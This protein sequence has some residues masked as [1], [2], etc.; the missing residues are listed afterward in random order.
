MVEYNNGYLY[1][2][3]VFCVGYMTT[4]NEVCFYITCNLCW[5]IK[6]LIFFSISK[7]DRGISDVMIRLNGADTNFELLV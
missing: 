7:I 4:D 5:L 2:H 3:F 1:L 6:W